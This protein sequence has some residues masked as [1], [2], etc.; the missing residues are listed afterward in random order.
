MKIH[1][2]ILKPYPTGSTPLLTA[3]LFVEAYRVAI[4]GLFFVRDIKC[5]PVSATPVRYRIGSPEKKTPRMLM[6]AAYYCGMP[7]KAE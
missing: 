1:S 3:L 2:P 7:L 6:T 5:A 4:G